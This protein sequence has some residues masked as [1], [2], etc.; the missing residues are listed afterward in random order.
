[1]I[2]SRGLPN[3]HLTAIV[4]CQQYE[5][6]F[7]VQL[8]SY[9]DLVYRVVDQCERNGC[10][11]SAAEIWHY[12]LYFKTSPL[13]APKMFHILTTNNRFRNST[14][15]PIITSKW[16]KHELH[17]WY[18]SW[19]SVSVMRMECD[20]NITVQQLFFLWRVRK[21]NST[22]NLVFQHTVPFPIP[23]R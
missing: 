8:I 14:Y 22:K 9:A 7:V 11:L 23:A 13:K 1:M 12:S 5:P 15:L 16:Q 3:R 10:L 19:K 20:I 2:P 18:N 21:F 17:I 4:R 6:L